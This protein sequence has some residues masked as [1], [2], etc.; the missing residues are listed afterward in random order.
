MTCLESSHARYREQLEALADRDVVH[1]PVDEA[2]ERW[3][4]PERQAWTRLHERFEPDEEPYATSVIA[5]SD[6]PQRIVRLDAFRDA[7]PEPAPDACV[8]GAGAAG[9]I[10]VTRIA[11]DPGLPTLAVALAGPGRRAV[12]RYHPGRRCT[13]R[14][15]E[16]TRTRFAKLYG[17]GRGKQVHADGLALWRAAHRGELGFVVAEPERFDDELRAVWQG[18][19]GGEPAKDRLRGPNVDEL[20][21]RMGCAAGSLARSSLRPRALRDRPGE[22]ARSGFRCAE[23]GRRVPELAEPARRLR[24]ALE[25]AHAA[26]AASDPR[27][28]HGALHASQ[29]LVYGS[30]LALLDYDSLALGDPELDAAVFLADA[31]VQNRARVPVERLNEAFLS[32]YE[33][34]AGALDPRLL[35]AYRAQGRLEKALR[36]ARAIRPDGDRK[37][38]RRLRLAYECLR[39][40]A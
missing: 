11:V 34:V 12:V 1:R 33:S 8:V 5:T 10:R 28:V 22:L 6:S 14:V 29:W 36:V 17:D 27:P 35:A 39:G 18:S 23:L 15:N 31:D 26:C 20:A 13:I 9:R 16:N 2:R 40:T 38:R 37:A 21:W 19:V 3:G 30:G 25:S 32:G 24:E 7:Q 4:W